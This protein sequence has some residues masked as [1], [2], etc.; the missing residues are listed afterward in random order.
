[1]SVKD[2][3]SLMGRF[4]SDEDNQLLG[5]ILDA[6]RRQY[7][8]A[9]Y[10]K[11][12][13]ALVFFLR[14]GDLL[15][16]ST[17][18]IVAMYLLYELYQNAEPKHLNPFA[19]IILRLVQNSDRKPNIISDPLPASAEYAILPK[20]SKHEW[21]FMALL[22]RGNAAEIAKKTPRQIVMS[23][24]PIRPSIDY[25][26]FEALVNEQWSEITGA[27]RLRQVNLLPDPDPQ[28]AKDISYTEQQAVLRTLEQLITGETPPAF[29]RHRPHF[30]RA[31]PPLHVAE[32][33]FA[34][35][36]PTEP[37]QLMPLWDPTGMPEELERPASTSSSKSEASSK[38]DQ[39]PN[40]EMRQLMSKAVTNPLTR[41]DSQ[42]LINF[43]HEEGDPKIVQQLGM[44]PAKFPDLVE[45]NPIVA[46]EVLLMVMNTNQVTEYFQQLVSTDVTIHSMEVVNKVI[47]TKELPEE[48]LNLY[49]STC[50]ST[51]ENI[52]DCF[53]QNRMVRLVCVFLQSLIRNKALNPAEDLSKEVQSFCVEFNQVR[54]A[55]GLY[56]LLKQ[57]E[58]G[59]S[60]EEVEQNA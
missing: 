51:C 19:M 44:N 59:L 23:E 42:T 40:R 55:A 48:F 33:E 3:Y 1:L 8:P 16:R 56:K 14:E 58:G 17:Q 41:H 52:K 45:Y 32:D 47:S 15:T 39:Q 31:G 9:E 2:L 12:G 27:S 46:H 25:S 21:F 57:L 34:W 53:L 4:F 38:E 22:L 36:H 35:L 26:K 30:I 18:R 11:V 60:P 20:L 49:I 10:F 28:A 54:E 6:F 43:L 37:S 50:I 7:S 29:I 24:I 13:L 5:D